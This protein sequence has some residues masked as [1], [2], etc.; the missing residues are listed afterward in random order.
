MQPRTIYHLVTKDEFLRTLAGQTYAPSSIARDGFLHCSG[1][2]GSTLRVLE[3]YFASERRPILVLRIDVDRVKAEVR[4]EPPAPLPGAGTTHL[5]PGMLFPH[6]YGALNLSAVTGV[7]T[8]SCAADGFPWPG[9]FEP[10][11][12]LSR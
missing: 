10:V 3:D 2:P 12:A 6:V 7:A 1:D 9:A 5:R 4:F 11:A 8:V